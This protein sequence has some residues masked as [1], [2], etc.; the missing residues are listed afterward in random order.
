VNEPE[1]VDADLDAF[2]TAVERFLRNLLP[3]G[4]VAAI[5]RNDAEALAAAR[6]AVDPNELWARIGAAGYVTPTWPK[7]YGGL[8]ASAKVGAA[9]AR[10]LGRYRI[11]RFNNPV[12][13]DLAGPAILRW[14]TEEQKERF[15]PAIARYEHIWCQLFSEPGAG[16][17]LAGLAT[18]AVHDGDAWTVR[19]QKVWTSLGD[20]ARYGLLLARTE[21]DVPKH[22]GITAFLMPMIHPGVTVRPLR[23]ITGD[24]EFC[25]VFF[26][27][28]RIDDAMRLGPVNEGWRVAVSVLSNERQSISGADAAL[29]GTVTGRSVMS[30]IERHAP[31]ADP[32]LRQR[33]ARAYI[34]D[35][36][37]TMT[38]QRAAAR[39]RGG[40]PPGPEASIGKLFFS[41]HTQRVQNLAV[42]LEGPAAQAWHAEDRWMQNTAWSFLR[43]RSKTIAGGTSEVQRNILGERVLGLPREPEFD[44]SVPWSEVPR[45]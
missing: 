21:P 17:D 30:L 43:V 1:T 10:V 39:R 24:A 35:R 29:P 19:G 38:K 11:P 37:V 16:S 31:V 5:D 41:E 23:Q 34:E 27:D 15:V 14:G 8:D 7:Q 22:G 13:V 28:A 42:D 33:L 44:R 3:A 36:L 32:S 4:W 20:I 12:G 2:V 9:I 26:D 40:Q 45:S 25:E 6:G 18:R